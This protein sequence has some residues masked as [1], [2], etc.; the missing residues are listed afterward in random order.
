MMLKVITI[1]VFVVSWLGIP[2]FLFRFPK[3]GDFGISTKTI[4]HYR[5]L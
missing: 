5:S 4:S 2:T 3:L 1:W